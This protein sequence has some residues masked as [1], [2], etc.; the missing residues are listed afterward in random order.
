MLEFFHGSFVSQRDQEL[1]E[2]LPGA[3][4]GP[5]GGGVEAGHDPLPHP[6]EKSNFFIT[7]LV[8]T[9]VIVVCSLGS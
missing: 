5:A 6:V 9:I 4:H 3:G 7:H 2:L 8:L 1:L